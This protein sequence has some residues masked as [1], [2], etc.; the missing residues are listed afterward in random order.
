L[1]ERLNLMQR[2]V[3]SAALSGVVMRDQNPSVPYTPEE[4][5]EESH[6][7]MTEGAAVVHI[8]PREPQTGQQTVNLARTAAIVEA[9]RDRCPG[10]IINL[11]TGAAPGFSGEARI[12]PVSAIEPEMASLD[13]NSMNIAR[14]INWKAGEIGSEFI[15]ENPFNQVLHMAKVMRQHGV[16][17]EIEIFDLGDLYAVLLLS[18]QNIFDEPLHFQLVFGVVGGMPYDL[19]VLGKMVGMLP[20]DGSWSIIGVG[21]VQFQAGMTAAV[22]GG[23]IRVGLE[24]NLRMPDGALAKG[25]YEQVRWAV[26]VAR[27]AGRQ[28]ATVDEAKEIFHV[29]PKACTNCRPR[30]FE[31][32]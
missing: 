27:L 2:L 12:A 26:Q 4:F 5:A 31:S 15:F 21:R 8:H 24:D 1:I 6:R 23:H 32:E 28:I 3:I 30:K 17:P 14:G 13:V 18:K 22:N 16:K 20:R 7:C 9:I 29:T 25:S 19:A 10:L 11:T